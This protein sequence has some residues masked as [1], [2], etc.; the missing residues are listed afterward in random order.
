M[1]GFNIN[2]F[3]SQLKTDGARP[4]LFEVQLSPGA[5]NILALLDLEHFSFM[6]KAGSLPESM[7]GVI[8]VGYYG[9][10]IKVAGD[11][12]FA[13]WTVTIINDEDFRVRNALE[14]WMNGLDQNSTRQFGDRKRGFGSSSTAY[15]GDARIIQKGKD[16]SNAKSYNFANLWPSALS[17][18]DMSWDATDQISEFQV[19]FQYDYWTAIEAGIV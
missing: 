9:R 1:S 17:P 2:T 18:I 5:A 19:T 7:V 4:S 8:E 11:R 3:R 16:G 6:C 10:K 15:V 12:T 14:R 13:D